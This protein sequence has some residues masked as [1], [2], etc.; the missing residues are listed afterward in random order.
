[1]TRTEITA[2]LGA[3]TPTAKFND[4]ELV[5]WLGPE[6]GYVRIDSEW[7]AIRINSNDRVTEAR[8]VTD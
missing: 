2:L 7:L 5:Y 6:R 3:D 4:Y 8:L 1:M